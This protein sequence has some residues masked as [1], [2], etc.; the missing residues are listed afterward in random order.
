MNDLRVSVHC[1]HRN[2]EI[3]IFTFF[4]QILVDF[5]QT[6]FKKLDLGEYLSLKTDTLLEKSD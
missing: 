6:F 4:F 1:F 5:V 2:K 3:Y